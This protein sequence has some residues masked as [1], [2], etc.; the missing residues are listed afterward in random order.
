MKCAL[1]LVA[2]A[3]QPITDE[4]SCHQCREYISCTTTIIV[5][6]GHEAKTLPNLHSTLSVQINR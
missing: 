5:A 1:L 6:D 3:S 4:R 2:A